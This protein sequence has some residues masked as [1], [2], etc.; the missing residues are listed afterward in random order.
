MRI[1]NQPMFINKNNQAG[2]NNVSYPRYSRVLDKDIFTPTPSFTALKKS[3]FSG[4]DFAVVEKFKAPIEQFNT[5]NDFLNWAQR[6]YFRICCKDYGGRNYETI[7]K[8][9]SL[10]SMWDQ[11]LS[12]ER[13]HYTIPEKLVIIDG[14]TKELKPN[15]ETVCPV[16]NRNILD[17]TISELREGLAKDK[18]LQFDFGKMYKANLRKMYLEKSS[19]NGDESKWVI[20]PSGINDP[21]HFNENVEK[22][23]SLS[24]HEWCTKNGGARVY[25][26][27]GDMHIYMDKGK[28]KLAIRFNEDVVKEINGEMND[29]MI[30]PEYVNLI[31]KYMRDNDFLT[32]ERVDSILQCSKIKAAQAGYQVE[33][34]VLP[35]ETIKPEPKPAEKK[36]GILSGFFGLFK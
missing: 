29:Y 6:E 36:K 23:Q 9:E 10:V 26:A 3:Q 17:N 28:P 11:E 2:G 14:I 34:F 4:I 13:S 30:P 27:D 32:T 21:E 8:R 5:M 18:K 12:M 16:F 33:D 19:V 24:C 15:T 20:I 31:S 7:V 22:L 25:L 35:A 1:S